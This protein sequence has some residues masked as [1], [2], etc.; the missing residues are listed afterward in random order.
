MKD[1]AGGVCEEEAEEEGGRREEERS[2]R[3][4]GG[5]GR[6]KGLGGDRLLL[7]AAEPAASSCLPGPRN[8]FTHSATRARA[9]TFLEKDH[10]CAYSRFGGESQHLLGHDLTFSSLPHISNQ[11]GIF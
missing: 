8:L 1:P 5:P 7:V 9:A 10:T 4:G 6:G 2:P 11:K 3:G